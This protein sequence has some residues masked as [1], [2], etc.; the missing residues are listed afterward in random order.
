MTYRPG[1]EAFGVNSA[2]VKD[3]LRF[4][5][6]FYNPRVIQAIEALEDSDMQV[7]TLG[8]VT[9]DIYIPPRFKRIYVD[10]DHGVPFLQGSHVVQ[11]QPSDLKY[12]SKTATR[13]LQKWII[14]A[15]WI[16]VTCSGTIG[17]VA[18]APP[19]WGGWAASQH[20]LRII[21]DE[22]AC[23][24][25]YLAAFLSSP[26]GQA[27]LTAQ[28]YGAVVDELTEEQAAAVLVPIPAN[29][30]Q[31]RQVDTINKQMLKSVADLSKAVRATQT[32]G[33]TLFS[34]LPALEA[35]EPPLDRDTQV[36]ID[37]DP[38]DALRAMLKPPQAA[39]R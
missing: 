38:E 10:A 15:G 14:E 11:V 37:A 4:D 22:D 7:L 20:I 34:L 36:K 17:R 2:I 29:D 19:H 26:I 25:G 24:H 33:T 30:A 9:K 39:G 12:I 35:P 13:N 23:P 8:E 27:Q 31:R 32:A 6:S 16:L 5:A 1:L 28:I 21:P 3:S 18:I